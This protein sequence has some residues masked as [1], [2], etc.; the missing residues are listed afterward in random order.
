MYL[1]KEL[2]LNAGVLID[3]WWNVNNILNLRFQCIKVVLIDTWWNVNENTIVQEIDLSIVLIDTWWNV[4]VYRTKRSSSNF[5]FNR[6]MV[7]CEFN[8][9]Y[10]CIFKAEVL[11]DT[12]WNVNF[13]IYIKFPTYRSFNRYMVECESISR[14]VWN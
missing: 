7:E 1:K 2:R 11:I 9:L 6:Y 10:F 13:F 5:R 4:N 14:R 8:S 12:W 3:T